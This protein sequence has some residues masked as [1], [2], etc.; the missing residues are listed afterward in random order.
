VSPR[1]D[2]SVAG[3]AG[4]VAITADRDDGS[5][6]AFCHFD[7]WDDVRRLI[8]MALRPP[9]VSGM[10]TH[11]TVLSPQG[12]DRDPDSRRRVGSSV[13][14]RGRAAGAALAAVILF[15]AVAACSPAASSAPSIALPSIN[16][17]AA[18]SLGTQAA[19]S[20]LDDLDAAISANES[21]GGLTTDN[22]T[23]LKSLSASIRTA[24]ETGDTTAAQTAVDQLST[25]VAS[26]LSGDTAKQLQDAVAALKAALAGS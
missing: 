16:A 26:G 5:Q 20:A 4:G 7:A 25:Q 13:Q 6:S 14:I 3:R 12:A 10:K 19:L 21:S 1:D 2:S 17:S 8:Q 9:S 11:N 18:A 15:A 22:A 23:S 24:L